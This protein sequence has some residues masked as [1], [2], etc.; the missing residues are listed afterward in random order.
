M[1]A[2]SRLAKTSCRN[3][4]TEC[5][6]GGVCLNIHTGSSAEEEAA[7]FSIKLSRHKLQ[8]EDDWCNLTASVEEQ[9]HFLRQD[10]NILLLQLLHDH[11]AARY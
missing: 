11:I 9:K 10:L 8:T 5:G 4:S 1:S 3:L 6:A 2:V 7:G